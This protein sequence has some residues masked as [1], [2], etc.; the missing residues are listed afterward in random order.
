MTTKLVAKFA[1]I[2]VIKTHKK[3]TAESI[4]LIGQAL[5]RQKE[6]L[7]HG[8]FL[9]WIEVEFGMSR[10]AANKIMHVAAAFDSKCV[11]VTHLTPKVLYE[12]AA[13]STPDEVR[14]A[15]EE[16][17]VDGE[18]VDVATVKKLKA[19]VSRTFLARMEQATSCRVL[20][21]PVKRRTTCPPFPASPMPQRKPRA[22]TPG[23]SAATP[24]A[25]RKSFPKSSIE[26]AG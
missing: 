10:S 21:R 12:L 24:I 17:T 19:L 1:T 14:T 18:K 6:R 9:P 26:F 8:M 13:P 23:P 22:R 7:P 20:Q 5:Q 3:R 15:A 4:I 11:T 25:E 2:A 16:M